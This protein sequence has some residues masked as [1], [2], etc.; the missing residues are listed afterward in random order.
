[1]HK[2]VLLR[3]GES[4]WNL[5]N[6]FTGWTDVDLTPTGIEQARAAGILLREAGKFEEAEQAYRRALET[7]PDYALAHYNLGVLLDVYLRRGAEAIPQYEAYQSSLA[8]PDKKVA[9]WL[10]DL[11]RRFGT[12]TPQVAKENGE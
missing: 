5:S 11:R 2:L 8:E 6:R 4:T 7:D 3:H 12:A 1:M 10:I 9:G